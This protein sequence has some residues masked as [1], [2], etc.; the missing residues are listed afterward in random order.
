MG[1]IFLEKRSFSRKVPPSQG[2]ALLPG[3]GVSPE[4]REGPGGVVVEMH[5]E[6]RS[7]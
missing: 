5:L 3:S 1:T 6:R 7:E 2:D 4:G